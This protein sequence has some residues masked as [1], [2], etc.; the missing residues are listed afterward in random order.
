MVK[1]LVNP[2]DELL[3]TAMIA[4]PND[5]AI[6]LPPAIYGW[7]GE[8]PPIGIVSPSMAIARFAHRSISSTSHRRSSFGPLGPT[9]VGRQN[10]M[11]GLRHRTISV[12]ALLVPIF[13]TLVS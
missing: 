13:H 11:D 5:D 1:F 10:L 7:S 12:V 4:L 6:I 3:H 2:G 9:L 8:R